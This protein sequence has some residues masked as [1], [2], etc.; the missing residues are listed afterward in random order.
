MLGYLTM[1]FMLQRRK[2]REKEEEREGGRKDSEFSRYLIG[3]CAT[4]H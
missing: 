2:R 1:M 3:F 4:G